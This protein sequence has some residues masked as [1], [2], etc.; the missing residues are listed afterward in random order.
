M[1]EADKLG[2]EVCFSSLED[3]RIE[4]KK[5]YPLE[6]ILFVVLSGKI[7][8][9]ESWRDFVTFGRE[10]LSFLREYFP[11]KAGIPCKDTF[12][13]LFAALDS[14]AFKTCFVGWVKKFQEALAPQVV[15][16]DGK[17]LC[18]SFDTASET[19]AI[20]MVSAFATDA[21]LVL[22]QQK[23][24]HKSNEITAIPKLLDLLSLKGC[25][26]TLDAMGCQKEIAAHIVSKGAE[27]VLALKGNQGT[28]H[29]D[30]RLFFE[31]EKDEKG[32]IE[33][34]YEEVDKGH[35]RIEIRK[36]SVTSNMRWLRQKHE[37]A[38]LKSLVM[39][40]ETQIK[41]GKESHEKRFFITSLP[42][43]AKTIARAV[44]AHWG[45][46]NRVHWTLDVVFSEDL[47]RVRT[48]NAAHNMAIVRH[49]VL[50]MLRRAKQGMKNMSLKGLRK[51]AAWGNASLDAILK[52][53]F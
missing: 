53:N 13:R 49:F 48:K 37:W 43:D 17:R 39:L 23:V 19:S 32:V 10:K 4:R 36:C 25:V 30:V 26:V 31:T 15:A 52:Q 6:E 34:F 45:V 16:I 42:P 5:L 50:N 22:G 38:K 7:C 33:D 21:R 12:S 11:F 35:G 24:D 51:K 1:E 9:A 40:E 41:K 29:D 44:R 27:Y 46:E 20:H 14:E 28:L 3:P 8:G 47:S 18:K 2:F